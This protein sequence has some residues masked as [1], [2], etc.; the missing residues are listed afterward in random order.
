MQNLNF[1][2]K[3]NI[4]KIFENLSIAELLELKEVIL[5]IIKRKIKIEKNKKIGRKIFKKYLFGITL[6]TRK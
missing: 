5:Q 6:T 2:Q 3:G 1:L 4:V